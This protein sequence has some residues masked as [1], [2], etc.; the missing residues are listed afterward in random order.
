MT[1]SCVRVHRER[2]EQKKPTLHTAQSEHWHV[3]SIATHSEFNQW[4]SPTTFAQT[5]TLS[6]P[7]GIKTQTNADMS[8]PSQ[9]RGRIKTKTEQSVKLWTDRTPL[10]WTVDQTH[11]TGPCERRHWSW[12]AGR[13]W[14]IVA[15]YWLRLKMWCMIIMTPGPA[16][17]GF[18]KPLQAIMSKTKARPRPKIVKAE[19][20]PS[21][22]REQDRSPGLHKHKV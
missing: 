7:R 3:S 11:H 13:N 5:K 17:Q 10:T 9:N 14:A 2:L 16:C 8:R 12:K 21:T 6:C 20:R 18:E 15:S 19:A 1:S 4:Q 22:S